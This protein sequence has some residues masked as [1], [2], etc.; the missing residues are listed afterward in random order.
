MF[1]IK[2][3]FIYFI[4]SVPG[5]TSDKNISISFGSALPPWVIT[6]EKG[7]LNDLVRD[8]LSPSGYK[9]KI[10]LHP[11]ARRLVSYENDSVDAVS[12]VNLAVIKGKNLKGY[13]TGNLYAYHNYAISLSSNKFSLDKVSDL[14]Q[15]SLY[16]WQGAAIHLGAEYSKMSKKNKRYRETSQQKS[17]VQTL[18]LNR[19]NFIQM[20]DEIFKYYLKEVGKSKEFNIDQSFDKFDLLGK[21]PNGFLFKSKEVRDAC[22]SNIKKMK[23]DKYKSILYL[24]ND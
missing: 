17:Q 11:Y 2:I 9:V 3:I 22:V 4:M 8:C 20:D 24:Q 5:H 19:V 15:Y 21:S 6:T 1:I 12:D 23:A 10:V 7:I 18:L 16:S 13:F 14:S